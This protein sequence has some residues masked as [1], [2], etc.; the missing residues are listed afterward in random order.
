MDENLKLEL[1]LLENQIKETLSAKSDTDLFITVKDLSGNEKEL[2]RFLLGRRQEI[3]NSLLMCTPAEVDRIKD[4]NDRLLS[5]TN[6]LKNKTYRLYK[7]LLQ[8]GYDPDFDEDIM[9]EGTLKYIVDGWEDSVL[10]MEEDKE[11][12][13]DFLYMMYL[14][15]CHDGEKCTY[16]CAS[17]LL[18]YDPKHSLD[19]SI[20]DIPQ[21]N[22]MDKL[23][24]GVS[25]NHVGRFKDLCICHA[26]YSLVS[27]NLY[28]FPDLLR[29]NDFWCEVKVTH[30]LLTDLKGE[31]YSVINRK[32]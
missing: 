21:L 10:T 18:S 11:Y 16:A 22:H 27:D 5:L 25:W 13:S 3:L 1:F 29:M 30:Q 6:S 31:R 19:V 20:K 15:Y 8:T 26:I 17:T 23:E 12:D 28:S 4:V 32:Q 7:A 24:D 14:I 9:I 2:V